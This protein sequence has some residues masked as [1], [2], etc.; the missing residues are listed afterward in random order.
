MELLIRLVTANL[1]LTGWVG[2]ALMM[3]LLVARSAVCEAM[4]KATVTAVIERSEP[5]TYV[6]D[7]RRGRTILVVKPPTVAPAV[8][9]VLVGRRPS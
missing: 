8:A 1:T 4:R 5:G 7:R 3:T 6:V 9:V 2:T